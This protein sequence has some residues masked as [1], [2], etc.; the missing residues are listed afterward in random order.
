MDFGWNVDREGGVSLVRCRA[1]NDDAVPRR[2]RIES[3]L[4][5]PVLPPRR[6][7]VPEDGWDESGV[8]LRLD[9]GE[10]RAFGFAA[11][12]P[13]ADPPV[14][15]AE[16]AAVDPTAESGDAGL[17]GRDD[18][19]ASATAEALRRLGDHRPPRDA[20][21]G[22]AIGFGDPDPEDDSDDSAHTGGSGADVVDAVDADE[23]PVDSAALGPPP[24]EPTNWSDAVDARLN[25]VEER[26]DRA[27]RLTDADLATATEAVAEADGVEGLSGLDER[28]AADAA[29]LRELSERASA[30]AARAEATDAPVAALERL[31]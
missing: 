10:R 24:G 13:P 23:P 27:E 30:L 29:R 5:A 1:R 17:G 12:A 25:T 14:E 8:T 7:G 21:A 18:G 4:G 11:R 26:I 16:V 9:P 20:V 2:V 19:A 22:E 15:V 3:R 6:G 28:V 31:A